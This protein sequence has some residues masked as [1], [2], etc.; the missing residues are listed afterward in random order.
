[1]ND[2]YVDA[3]KREADDNLNEVNLLQQLSRFS[4]LSENK[5]SSLRLISELIDRMDS[6]LNVKFKDSSIESLTIKFKKKK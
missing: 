1:M 6:E 5:Y 2:D 4:N 3:I